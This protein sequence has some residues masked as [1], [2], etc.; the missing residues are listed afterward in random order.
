MRP[1]SK[2]FPQTP[3][4]WQLELQSFIDPKAHDPQKKPILFIPGY[5]MNSYILANHPTSESIIEHLCSRGFAVWAANLRGQGGARRV[6]G[7]RRISLNEL[8]CVDI[9]TAID[10]V[11]N[12][13]GASSLIYAGCSLGAAIGYG[14]LAHNPRGHGLDAMVALGGPFRWEDPH[15]MVSLLA[16][17]PGLVGA[18]P[19]KGTRQM[20]AVGLSLARKIPQVISPYMNARAVNLTNPAALVPGVDDPTP[21]LNRQ[22]AR[23]IAT[24]DLVVGGVHVT[25]AIKE[26]EDVDLL[27]I[28]ANKDGIVPPETALSVLDYME[29]GRKDVIKAGDDHLWFAHADLFVSD[30]ARTIVFEP[31]A[32][33]L[34]ARQR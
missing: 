21:Y 12:E 1:V 16:R 7:P 2:T 8:V 27:C 32:E 15:P 25:S 29:A 9:P 4:G 23:W 18:L 17:A 10:A 34:I 26:V 14:Y 33:W 30:H 6:G 22:L 19:I 31:L 28:F 3:D 24:K 13:S 20:A 11:L 5:G